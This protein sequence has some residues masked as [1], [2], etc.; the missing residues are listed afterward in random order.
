MPQ[1]AHVAD[2]A[3]YQH[4]SRELERFARLL[5]YESTEPARVALAK[6]MLRLAVGLRRVV[7]Q[8]PSAT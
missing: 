3:R 6:K 4:A 8:W 2:V 7:D 5:V 1:V